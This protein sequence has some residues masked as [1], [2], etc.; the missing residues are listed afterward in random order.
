M[1]RLT[2][3][4]WVDCSRDNNAGT[5]RD[6]GLD[7]CGDDDNESNDE[8]DDSDAYDSMLPC[9]SDFCPCVSLD[10]LLTSSSRTALD[11]VVGTGSEF[12]QRYWKS[13][14]RRSNVARLLEKDRSPLCEE[15]WHDGGWNK[16][17][18]CHYG[19]QAVAVVKAVGAWHD[20]VLRT[21]STF[22]LAGDELWAWFRDVHE[23][24]ERVFAAPPLVETA[25]AHKSFDELRLETFCVAK[26]VALYLRDDTLSER[27]STSRAFAEFARG[28]AV[29]E[30]LQKL[31]RGAQLEHTQGEYDAQRNASVEPVMLCLCCKEA[32]PL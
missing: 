18:R 25:P 17:S 32:S 14:L 2:C 30:L 10:D 12:L 7:G 28:A 27:M 3:A 26:L 4:C 21:D 13:F 24:A 5:V 8:N 31:E 23:C 22:A 9:Q 11:I 19:E 6:G 16:L 1:Q 20:D 15:I 29:S